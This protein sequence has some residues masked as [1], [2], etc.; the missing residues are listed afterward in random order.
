MPGKNDPTNFALPQ[1]PINKCLLPKSSCYSTFYSSSN[2]NTFVLNNSIHIYGN[3]G[4]MIDTM[5]D[6]TNY[7]NI[8][9]LM[10][11]TLLFRHYMPSAPD[12]LGCYPFYDNDPFIVKEIP[13]IYITSNQ[14]KFESKIIDFNGSKVLLL[15]VPAFIESKTAVLV[16]LRNFE[17]NTIQ[18]GKC[19]KQ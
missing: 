15:S 4:E 3:T 18:L 9:D 5:M 7:D 6:Y 14:K 10:E 1:Q 19:E 17:C 16:N 2:P 8:L 11:K 13:H 12:T